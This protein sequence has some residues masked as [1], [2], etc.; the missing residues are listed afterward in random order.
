MAI[1]YIAA[2]D[3]LP[4]IVSP[5]ARKIIALLSLLALSAC[6]ATANNTSPP[7]GAQVVEA[8]DF[9]KSGGT[10]RYRVLHNM[11]G[12]G[13]R[14]DMDQ[15][16]Y[17]IQIVKGQ[18]RRMQLLDGKKTPPKQKGTWLYPALPTTRILESQE[19]HFKFPL[20]VGK[21]WN[22]W[23][24]LVRWRDTQSTLTG[25]ETV[26]TPAGTFEAYRIERVMVAF[27]GIYNYYD[28]EIYYYSPETRS[29]IKYDYKREMK[30]LV[31][32]PKYSLEETAS[33][34]LLSYKAE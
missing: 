27:A 25:I 16:E 18:Y 24:L 3:R 1:S 34:E 26:T 13:Y 14:S 19:Q 23:Q 12:G 33:F 6:T 31:G 2:V 28:T 5:A 8:P 32:D 17:E 15:G 7:P 22:G 11:F 29:V 21:K 9:D 10:W 4:V 30:D 20:W